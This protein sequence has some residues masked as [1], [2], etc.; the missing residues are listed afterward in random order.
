MTKGIEGEEKCRLEHINDT[1]EHN[2]V[3]VRWCWTTLEVLVDVI[4]YDNTATQ[5]SVILENSKAPEKE[6]WIKRDYEY[7][8]NG[9][10]AS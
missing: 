5:K 9:M 10:N 4:L 2:K 7:S 8:F 3:C 6:W 1:V